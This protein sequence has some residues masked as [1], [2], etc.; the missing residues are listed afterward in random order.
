MS[1]PAPGS[2][3]APPQPETGGDIVR[4]LGPAG[5]LAVVA[6]VMPVA[7]S[8]ILFYN[9]N[10]VADFLRARG[11]AGVVIFAAAFAI[12]AG[13]ALLPTYAQCAMAGYVFHTARGFPASLAGVLGAAILAYEL[14]RRIAADRVEAIL[15]DH[16]RWRGV[17]DALV[18]VDAGGHGFWRTVGIVALIRLPPN[19]PFALTN[20]VLA[21]VR[22]PRAAYLLGTLLGIAPRSF[23][24]VY[25]GA[26]VS[27]FT[28]EQ[29]TGRLPIVVVGI[30]VT[31]AVVV[32]IGKLAARALDRL[33]AGRTEQRVEAGS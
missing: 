21:S 29:I 8:A 24:A 14:N 25:I 9:A 28:K 3:P 31:L 11:D 6:A 33:G 4:R 18:G 13:L 30:V 23:L 15:R 7:G 1:T 26:G 16:P 10:T 5:I 19:S 20:L 27:A 17:R 22:V 12:T 32:I 2:P